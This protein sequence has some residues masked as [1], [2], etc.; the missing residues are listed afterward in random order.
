MLA[1]GLDGGVR[2][3]CSLVLRPCEVEVGRGFPASGRGFLLSC[4]ER[5]N[6]VE[7][8]GSVW[9]VVTR[10]AEIRGTGIFFF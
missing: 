2:S 10:E 1:T 7:R 9:P 3:R 8:S 5:P 4:E 6:G